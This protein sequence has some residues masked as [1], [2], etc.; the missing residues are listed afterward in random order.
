MLFFHA[1]EQRGS[2]FSVFTQPHCIGSQTPGSVIF[3]ADSILI[4]RRWQLGFSCQRRS[5]FVSEVNFG[6]EVTAEQQFFH[7]FHAGLAGIGTGTGIGKSIDRNV[8]EFDTENI[9][10]NETVFRR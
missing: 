4:L 2:D 8:M 3:P 6:I 7:F 1:P 10:R 5:F 9:F